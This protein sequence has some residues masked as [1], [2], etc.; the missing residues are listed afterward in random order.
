VIHTFTT[1]YAGDDTWLIHYHTDI[2]L[3]ALLNLREWRDDF[4]RQCQ[5]VAYN[6]DLVYSRA[7][8]HPT[9][10]GVAC[11]D[12]LLSA[13]SETVRVP[14]LTMFY[15]MLMR[16]FGSRE[17]IEQTRK[18][19]GLLAADVDSW[20]EFCGALGAN[21]APMNKTL[22]QSQSLSFE[23]ALEELRSALKEHRPNPSEANAD[24]MLWAAQK[25]YEDLHRDVRSATQLEEIQY[26]LVRLY[27]SFVPEKP[28]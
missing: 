17:L 10:L 18:Q 24:W 8:L 28:L 6:N 1:D 21:P 4:L 7:F 9:R 13:S 2:P 11:I 5:Y 20:D 15:T 12:T 26:L 14:Y 25:V 3:H 22:Y 23:K 27:R 16:W 19:L